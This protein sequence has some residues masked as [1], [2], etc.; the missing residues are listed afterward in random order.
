MLRIK[1]LTTGIAA[2]AMAGLLSTASASAKELILYT[3]GGGTVA[4]GTLNATSTSGSFTFDEPGENP[5]G[6]VFPF[7]FLKWK[8]TINK[9]GNGYTGSVVQEDPVTCG[10]P[11]GG[12]VTIEPDPH[13]WSIKLGPSGKGKVKSTMGKMQLVAMFPDEKRC[14]YGGGTETLSFQVGGPG[15]HPVPLEPGDPVPVIY[16]LRPKES[17]PGCFVKLIKNGYM[18]AVQFAGPEEVPLYVRNG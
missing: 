1:I 11:G 16:K 8:I 7:E 3:E 10:L 5:C 12:V 2:L 4:S 9:D 18:Y 6:T 15:S 13:P 14:V 17:S